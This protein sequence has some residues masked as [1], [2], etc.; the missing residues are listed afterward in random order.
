M[1]GIAATCISIQKQ[2]LHDTSSGCKASKMLSELKAK[3]YGFDYQ[4]KYDSSNR[5]IGVCWM[6]SYMRNLWIH[7]GDLLF[8]DCKKKDMNCLYWPNHC[9]Q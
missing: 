9:Q 1:S 8:L 6:T 7:Y 5:P 2:I 4:I 3:S